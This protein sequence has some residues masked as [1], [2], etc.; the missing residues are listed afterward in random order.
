MELVKESK[1]E[2]LGRARKAAQG[3]WDQ[4]MGSLTHL[5]KL[6]ERGG[7]SQRGVRMGLFR[8]VLSEEDFE[9][10]KTELNETRAPGVGPPL[11]HI[12]LTPRTEI[13]YPTL[14]CTTTPGMSQYIHYFVDLEVLVDP[15][16]GILHASPEEP[17]G[18]P[19]S[20]PTC[21]GAKTIPDGDDW[22]TPRTCPTCQGYGH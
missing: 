9:R 18:E 2:E 10:Y 12:S 14:V 3:M 5:R 19:L 16:K 4:L 6:E 7:I 8:M 20:C 22:G 15:E 11:M 17:K 21:N 1:E 13:Q